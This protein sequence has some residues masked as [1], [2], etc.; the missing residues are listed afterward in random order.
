[1]SCPFVKNQELEEY[2]GNA[3]E[4][5]EK[6]PS[7]LDQ[8]TLDLVN[9]SA[10]LLVS[11]METITKA[12]YPYMFEKYPHIQNYFNPAHHVQD[13]KTT[14]P[15]ALAHAIIR[16][17]GYLNNPEGLSRAIELA[18]QKHCALSVRAHHYPIIAEC[19]MWAVAKILGSSLT[20]E[21]AAAWEKA[22]LS[23]ARAF[24]EREVEIYETQQKKEDGWFGWKVCKI[25]MK[26]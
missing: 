3:K 5:I 10:P 18:A 12:F 1:M 23:V 11:N 2:K 13:G 6:L 19:L 4:I 17:T 26:T 14:Q 20:P 15:F 24:I 22:I 7:H 25:F 16:Y 8:H 21:S 9:S